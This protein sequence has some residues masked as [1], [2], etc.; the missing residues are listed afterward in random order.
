MRVQFVCLL[1]LVVGALAPGAGVALAGEVAAPP[2]EVAKEA[3]KEE[4]APTPVHV[5][6]ERIRYIRDQNLAKILGKA[7]IIKKDLRIDAE[8]VN[9]VMDPETGQFKQVVAEG[10]VRIYA[11]KPIPE[12][13]TER[14]ELELRED[15][16]RAICQKAV[17]DLG[18]EVVVLSGTPKKQPMVWINKDQVQADEIRY[19]H[20]ADL[21]T[22]TGRVKLSALVP[23]TQMGETP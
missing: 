13:T 7:C 9:A 20:K 8:N 1:L 2:A 6:G 12:R 15:G 23:A 10:N 17:Y 16:R 5:W 3:P 11:V 14:P 22:F 21:T 18:T 4:E 19:D